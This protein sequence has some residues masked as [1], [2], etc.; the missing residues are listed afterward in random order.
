MGKFKG[1]IMVATENEYDDFKDEHRDKVHKLKTALN[2]MSLKKTQQP[3]DFNLEKLETHEG[4]HKF[5]HEM[6]KL[7]VGHL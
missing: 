7:G 6:L 4:R 5:D 1:L 2:S 3:I